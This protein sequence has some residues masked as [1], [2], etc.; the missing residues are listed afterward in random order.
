MQK[1]EKAIMTITQLDH[2]TLQNVIQTFNISMCGY[3]PVSAAIIA[4]KRLGATKGRLLQYKTSGDISGDYSQVVG[5]AS[6]ALLR[7]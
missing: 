2:E 5:Y 4:G 7:E 1:D 6:I 3:G